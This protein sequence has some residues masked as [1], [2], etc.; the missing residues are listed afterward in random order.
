MAWPSSPWRPAGSGV[1]KLGFDPGILIWGGLHLLIY[2]PLAGEAM[3]DMYENQTGW[4]ERFG[5]DDYG[6]NRLK[7]AV[8]SAATSL[9]TLIFFTLAPR[10]ASFIP[11]A[12]LALAGLGTYGLIRMRFWGV[13]ALAL[14]TAWLGVSML[15]QVQTASTAA[16]LTGLHGSLGLAAMVMMAMSVAPFIGP[17]YRFIRDERI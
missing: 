11:L 14:G 5:L 7:K 12:A 2:L 1:V 10:Q 4:R 3:A 8:G 16:G 6:V 15:L 13:A 17:A 9:P